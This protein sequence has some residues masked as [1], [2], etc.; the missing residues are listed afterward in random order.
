MPLFSF[1][2]GRDLAPNYLPNVL[3]LAVLSLISPRQD[4]DIYKDREPKGLGLVGTFGLF[5]SRASGVR[6]WPK[7][8]MPEE[9]SN[10]TIEGHGAY[11]S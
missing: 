4:A 5:V 9:E 6:S 3:R 10:L 11:G 7:A 8:G 2:Y 1:R